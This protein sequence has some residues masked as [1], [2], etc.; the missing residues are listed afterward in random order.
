MACSFAFILPISTAPN[1]LVFSTGKL[2]T[3]DLIKAG[4]ILNFVLVGLTV[5][6][7]NELVI[8]GIFGEY[9]A[10]A[11]YESSRGRGLSDG[12]GG[13]GL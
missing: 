11:V 8:Q 13:F 4:V 6:W 2:V 12:M 10:T 9:N 7:S 5:C 3:T 1:A